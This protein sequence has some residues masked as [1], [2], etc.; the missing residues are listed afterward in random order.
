MNIY[1]LIAITPFIFL[2]YGIWQH[3]NISLLARSVAKRHCDQANVQLLDD[4]VLLKRLSICRS[5]HSLFAFKRLY[6]FEFSSLGDFRYQG[7]V[8][9]VGKRMHH[10]EL[11]PFK[12]EYRSQ[13]EANIH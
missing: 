4:N 7:N 9:F 6:R 10:I 8:T 11:E 5:R 12:M 2:A 3:N 13:T 1:D